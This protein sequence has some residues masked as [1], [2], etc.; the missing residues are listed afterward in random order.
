MSKLKHGF[1]KKTLVI[2]AAIL[3]AFISWQTYIYKSA[4]A[5]IP[6]PLKQSLQQKNRLNI[7]VELNF[8]AEEFHIRLFQRYGTVTNVKGN[9]VNILRIT[10]DNVKKVTRYYWVKSVQ[11]L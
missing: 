3:I 9:S 5:K 2:L 6:P 11:E 10:P 4:E 8:P 7:A 1:N